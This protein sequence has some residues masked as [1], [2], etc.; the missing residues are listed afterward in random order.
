[1]KTHSLLSNKVILALVVVLGAVLFYGF[2]TIKTKKGSNL[3][4]EM[5]PIN[6]VMGKIAGTD[7]GYSLEGR[8]VEYNFKGV[9]KKSKTATTKTAE[10]AK[11]EAQKNSTTKGEAGKTVKAAA[12]KAQAV[13]A[14]QLAQQK[15]KQAR[16]A[17]LRQRAQL[18]AQ[19]EKNQKQAIQNT[20]AQNYY[21]HNQNMNAAAQAKNEKSAQDD[22]KNTKSLEQWKSELYA[23]PSRET[24]L[25]LAQAYKNGEMT[26][27]DFYQITNELLSA[28]DD[29]FVGLG[30]YALRATPSLKSYIILVQNENTVSASYKA[31]IQDALMTYHQPQN[32][33]VIKAALQSPDKTLVLRSLQVLKI[34]MSSIQSGQTSTMVDPRY[35]RNFDASQFDLKDY[36]VFLPILKDII[37]SGD[38]DLISLAQ[39]SVTIINT[40]TLVAT[41]NP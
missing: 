29:K 9:N 34:G 13:K 39:Q 14:N 27:N 1:M 20:S 37:A 35:V 25:K 6:Y 4:S 28:Q 41:N 23:N 32:L 26:E 38:Q 18:Q 17:A 10:V 15:A 7:A 12:Q 5:S 11:T 22:T 16:E 33:Y 19:A 3:F 40:T 8:E 30:L 36:S 2:S 24:V 21:G 31:Y